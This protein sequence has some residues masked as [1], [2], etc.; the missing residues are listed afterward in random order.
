MPEQTREVSASP[1]RTLVTG[2][3]SIDGDPAYCLLAPPEPSLGA[4]LYH[5]APRILARCTITYRNMHGRVYATVSDFTANH[6]W[7]HTFLADIPRGIDELDDE[8]RRRLF[9]NSGT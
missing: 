9:P 3:I 6:E 8:V 2:D 1:G 5:D 7:R 4:M